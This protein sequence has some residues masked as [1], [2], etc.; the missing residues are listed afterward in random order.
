M[1]K[2]KLLTISLFVGLSMSSFVSADVTITNP[3][4]DDT[5]TVPD[6]LLK[7]TGGVG[8]V[9]AAVG[10]IMIV[11]AGILYLLSAGSPEKIATAKKAL[12]YAIMGIAV[13]LAASTIVAVI[14]QILGASTPPV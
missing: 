10:T 5:S 11:I 3:L 8:S 13:G 7:I 14:E 9:I 4:G 12:I 1:K 6:L 2:I